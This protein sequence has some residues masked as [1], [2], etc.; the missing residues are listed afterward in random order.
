[1]AVRRIDRVA[2]GVAASFGAGLFLGLAPAASLAGRWLP[3][4]VL[5][6]VA[7]GGLAVLSTSD[8][9]LST[10]PIS[11]RRL[12]FALGT[13]GR[14]AAAVALAGTVAVYLTPLAALG[15]VAAATALAVVGVSPVAVRL[16]AAFVPVVLLLVVIACFA[17]APV[18]PAVA[19]PDGGSVPG[20]LLAAGLLTVCVFGAEDAGTGSRSARLVVLAV[21][22]VLTLAVAAA[23]L[24]Q[25]GA[26]RLAISPAP[27]RAALAA[28]DA[29]PLTPLLLAAV[30][31]GC[32]FALL[33]VLR[34]LPVPGV[35]RV[36]L[37][38]AAGVATA[39]G[40]LLIP[41]TAALAA[42]AGLLLCDAALRAIALRRRGGHG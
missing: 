33:G 28:A 7:V 24:H 39:A 41:A 27:L 34:G 42:S 20:V 5:L 17:I 38:V 2:G 40:V 6:G 29:S 14:L 16:A 3:V 10:L 8:R 37:V 21:V 1:V 22:A 31:V 12:G 13:L 36:R 11:V 25:V 19:V 26:A 30:V 35:P 15:V 9:P 4:A 32:G 23:A 18:A